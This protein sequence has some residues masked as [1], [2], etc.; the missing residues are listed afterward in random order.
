MIQVP[1]SRRMIFSDW[2]GVAVQ[3]SSGPRS[4]LAPPTRRTRVTPRLP[5]CQGFLTQK[6]LQLSGLGFRHAAEPAVKSSAFDQATP[7]WTALESFGDGL[8]RR[9]FTISKPM[10]DRP[11]PGL[12]RRSSPSCP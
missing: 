5:G 12:R 6:R 2:R 10:T 11:L 3:R 7:S 1:L 4:G 8:A 9:Q